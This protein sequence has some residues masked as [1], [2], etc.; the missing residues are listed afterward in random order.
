VF[1]SIAEFLRIVDVVE[2]ELLDAENMPDPFGTVLKDYGQALER[3]RLLTYGQQIAALFGHLGAKVIVLEPRRP[4]SKGQVERTNGYLETSFMPLRSFTDLADAQNQHDPMV[5][6]GRFPPA[7]P[8][9]RGP[10][11]RRVVGG[12]RVPAG[13]GRGN[14][15]TL[16][17]A[18]AQQPMLA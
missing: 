17:F 7:P 14:C 4:Q 1:A 13:P 6:R 10:S 3:Y 8:P 5:G 15:A 18:Q 16:G 11:R 9:R 12:T 2:N